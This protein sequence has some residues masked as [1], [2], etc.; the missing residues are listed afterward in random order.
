MGKLSKHAILASF[1]GYVMLVLSAL[2]ISLTIGS[3]TGYY[4]SPVYFTL[5]LV[6]FRLVEL[7]RIFIMG[8]LV[9]SIITMNT[10]LKKGVGTMTASG[11][12]LVSYYLLTAVVFLAMDAGEFPYGILIPWII[13]V[14]VLG[15]VSSKIIRNM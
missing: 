14:Y 15:V 12:G 13:W 11:I 2:A 9:V 7:H 3:L 5:V 8:P 10:L 4:T 6:T 1:A